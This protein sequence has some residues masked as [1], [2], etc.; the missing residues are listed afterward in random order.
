[1]IESLAMQVA[2]CFAKMYELGAMSC[3]VMHL[4]QQ[5]ENCQLHSF[6]IRYAAVISEEHFLELQ[7]LQRENQKVRI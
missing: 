1:M 6:Y 4:Q 5:H 3:E 2:L 7:H